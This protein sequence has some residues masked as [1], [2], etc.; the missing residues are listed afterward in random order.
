[1]DATIAAIAT[2]VGSGGIGIIKISG[3]NAFRIAGA[4]FVPKREPRGEENYIGLYADKPQRSH[5]LYYGHIVDPDNRHVIDEVLLSAMVASRSYTR[6]DV[7]EI[8]AHGGPIV[9]RAIV[10]LVLKQ[11]ARLAE[12]GE[13]TRR[14]YLNGRIDL[15]QAEAVIDLINAKSL[16]SLEIA[17]LQIKGELKRQIEAI[18]ENLI[19]R[20]VPIEAAIDFP[21][22]VEH[23]VDDD[24]TTLVLE[25]RVLSEIDRLIQQYEN[26]RVYR[27]G[28]RIVVVGKPNV[29]KSSLV[30]RLLNED[31][32]IVT[33]VPGTT[34]DVIEER[35]NIGGIAVVINDTAGLHTPKGPIEIIGIQKTKE[36]IEKAD[37]IFFLIDAGSPV[38]EEDMEIYR[39]IKERPFLLIWN[40]IDLLEDE[41][42]LQ[43][44]GEWDQV[45]SVKVSALYDK[46]IK[47]LKEMVVLTC[48]QSYLFEEKIGIVP[49]LRH[50]LAL[51]KGRTSV[52]TAIEGINACVPSELIALDLQAAI[53]ALGE[54]IGVATREDL[55]SEIF[56][57]FCI[58]K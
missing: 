2:P 30:N 26:G 12:P 21:E 8:N 25:K 40:K 4:I 36:Y 35:V 23:L 14:A 33:E 16:R 48:G 52:E 28:L 43:I 51:K 5:Y 10:D 41:T 34:R 57:Q 37:L 11:G 27:E 1:M 9:M 44:P 29:G 13:F 54:I 47:R 53:D 42:S 31:R 46:G 49:N 6:E 20:L 39:Q 7:V 18:R 3:K 58:G 50:I 24:S 22:E 32:I 55:L 38:S 15:T 19:Q 17:A 56:D 45:K